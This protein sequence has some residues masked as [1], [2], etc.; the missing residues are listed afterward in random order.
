MTLVQIVHLINF[1][2]K[3]KGIMLRC[4]ATMAFFAIC[5]LGFAQVPNGFPTMPNTG[6]PQADAQAYEQAK[7]NWFS[8]N[9]SSLVNNAPNVTL[10]PT[11]ADNEAYE[12][13]KI[14]AS[15]VS[16]VNQADLAAHQR[17]ALEG[18]LS[19]NSDDLKANNP[20]LLEAYIQA[21]DMTANQSTAV[22]SATEYATFHQE[23]RAIVDANT[24]MFTILQ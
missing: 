12:I 4:L 13:A 8:N 6:D 23:L 9:P 19:Q 24:A 17:A 11:E 2:M 21:L 5:T 15:Q 3:N 10:S 22:I 20:R 18:Y 1:T 14:A 16:Q 7:L